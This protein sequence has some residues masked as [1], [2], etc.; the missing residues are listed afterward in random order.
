MTTITDDEL[1]A[2]AEGLKGKVVLITG[3]GKGIG[4]VRVFLYNLELVY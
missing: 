3:G 4:Q 1:F 2:H